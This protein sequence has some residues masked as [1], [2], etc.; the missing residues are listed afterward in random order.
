MRN[1][2]FFKT[3]ILLAA[4]AAA[5]IAPICAFSQ[6]KPAARTAASIKDSDIYVPDKV[7]EPSYTKKEASD[8]LKECIAAFGDS[9]M[10]NSY[11]VF[12]KNPDKYKRIGTRQLKSALVTLYNYIFDTT[13]KSNGSKT[14]QVSPELM[15]VTE[16]SD[17]WFKN[18][19][20]KA[21][22]LN[23][24]AELM[25]KAIRQKNATMYTQA[26]KAYDAKCDE[27]N[28]F[29]KKPERLDAA[30]LKQLAEANKAKRKAEYIALRKKQILEQEELARKALEEELKQ[31]SGSKKK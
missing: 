5:V 12:A 2:H 16:A 20:N 31:A 24:P 27:L 30:K 6:Q 29:V 19:Y 18:L 3:Q 28:K 10:P 1:N 9:D 22:E 25:D 15:E 7:L 14:S 13:V 17:A 8:L 21:L 4:L 23:E 11:D 26:K